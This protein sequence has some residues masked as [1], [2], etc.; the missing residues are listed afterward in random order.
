MDSVKTIREYETKNKTIKAPS[1]PI[2]TRSSSTKDV[3][4]KLLTKIQNKQ[5]MEMF[6]ITGKF[7]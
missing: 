7:Y 1:L 6:K 5:I 3:N 4:L 2:L